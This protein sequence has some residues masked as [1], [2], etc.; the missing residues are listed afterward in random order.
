MAT[1]LT[2]SGSPS[3]DSTTEHV[4]FTHVVPRLTGDDHAIRH[5]AVR[6]LPAEALL[7][8]DAGHPRLVA[9]AAQLAAADGLVIATPVYKA[10]YS[11]LLKAFLDVLPRRALAGKA[12]LPVVTGHMASHG[13]LVH[14]ALRTV[15]V[16]MDAAVVTPGCF[17]TGQAARSLHRPQYAGAR[18]TLDRTTALLRGVAARPGG[19]PLTGPRSAA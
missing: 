2:V 9:A 15:F 3:P 19:T 10:S 17:L 5:L 13:T 1:F 16:A 14:Q 11:G 4:L 8:G 6:E 12:V 18:A 7:H